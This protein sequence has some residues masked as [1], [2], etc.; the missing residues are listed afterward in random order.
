MYNGAENLGLSVHG[1][2]EVDL[3]AQCICHFDNAGLCVW[4][5]ELYN[6]LKTS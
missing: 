1:H 5:N 6:N 3:D 4:I 2:V